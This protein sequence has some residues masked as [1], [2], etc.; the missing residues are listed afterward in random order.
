MKADKA[1]SDEKDFDCRL[2]AEE[3]KIYPFR[4][5]A[6]YRNKW[7]LRSGCRGPAVFF[8]YKYSE[9]SDKTDETGKLR[10]SAAMFSDDSILFKNSKKICDLSDMHKTFV[11]KSEVVKGNFF[12]FF[13]G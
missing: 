4:K 12:L 1:A 10:V 9:Y 8:L 5:F 6:E 3:N 13:C 7:V 2:P 11:Q